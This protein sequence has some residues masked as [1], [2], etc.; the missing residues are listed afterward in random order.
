MR[1]LLPL[2]LFL[3]FSLPANAGLFDKLPDA[4]LVPMNMDMLDKAGMN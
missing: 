2:V 1:R 3:L 4:P